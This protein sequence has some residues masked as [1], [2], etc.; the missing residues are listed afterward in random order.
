MT[1]MVSVTSTGHHFNGESFLASI[2]RNG[3]L[4][5]FA[6]YASNLVPGRLLQ[7][8]A[9]DLITGQTEL[10]SQSSKGAPANAGSGITPWAVSQDGRYVVFISKATNL[11]SQKIV[12]TAVFRRDRQDRTTTLVAQCL[13]GYS[14]GCFESTISNDGHSVSFYSGVDDLVPGDT[15]GATDVFLVDLQTKSTVRVSVAANGAKV[16][17]S[18][19]VEHMSSVADSGRVAFESWFYNLVGPK[20]GIGADV[21]V[22]PGCP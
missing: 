8:Y 19:S 11:V 13:N 9:H 21:F 5:V 3:R 22:R 18:S 15:N 10:I 1:R 20:E 16:L 12:N 6:S 17:G 14:R 7:V 2:S 4:V